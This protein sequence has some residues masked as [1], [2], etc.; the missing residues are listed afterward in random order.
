MTR[1]RGPNS[2][3][4]MQSLWFMPAVFVIVSLAI[5]YL[6]SQV[7]VSEDSFLANFVFKGSVSSARQLLVVVTST[8]ITVTGLVFVLTV[9]ALQIASSQFSPRLLQF[10]LRDFGTRLV[11][12][13]FVATFAYS[14][15]GLFT[16]GRE[17]GSGEEFLPQLA[18]TGALLLALLSVGMLVFYI[19]HI[20]NS[21]RIDSIMSGVVRSTLAAIGR[22]HPVPIGKAASD[23]EMP[24]LPTHAFAVPIDRHGYF[25]G[26][27]V[28][29]LADAASRRDDSS[30]FTDR[31]SSD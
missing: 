20:T 24:N 28:D 5:G 3:E 12:S 10:F 4:F 15:A 30:R 23:D 9:I 26:V 8:M 2:F 1:R 19:Q 21:I 14:L 17:T 11:L 6:L 13:V 22:L 29:A 25:Q 7:D 27:D 18:V 16:V 31:S